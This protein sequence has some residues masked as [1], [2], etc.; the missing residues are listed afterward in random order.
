M[1][2]GSPAHSSLHVVSHVPPPVAALVI[3]TGVPAT[4]VPAATCAQTVPSFELPSAVFNAS[5]VA[6]APSG[7]TCP[8]HEHSTSMVFPLSRNPHRGYASVSIRNPGHRLVPRH[9][10]TDVSG[11]VPQSMP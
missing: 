2:S 10:V 6:T 1:H 11:S 3:D 7:Q 8:L 9:S 4:H 5:H